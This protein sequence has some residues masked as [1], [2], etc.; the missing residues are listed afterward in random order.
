MRSEFR[1]PLAATVGAMVMAASVAAGTTMARPTLGE[2]VAPDESELRSSG[3]TDGMATAVGTVWVTDVSTD[4]VTVFDAATGSTLT[5]IPVGKK[6]IGLTSPPGSSKVYVSNEGDGTVSV[7]S[8]T[9]LSVV[10]TIEMVV[11]SKPHH[12]ANSPDGR[13][14]YV[15][16]YGTASIAVI[17]TTSDTA[18]IVRSGR[19]GAKTHAIG[20]SPDGSALYVTNTKTND[21]QRLDAE[22]RVTGDPIAVGKGPS[23]VLISPDG[24]TAYV[25]IKDENEVEIVDLST[26]R[27]VGT[28]AVG[29]E[30]DTLTFASGNR[31]VAA[32][33]G[34][35]PS[36]LV[37]VIEPGSSPSASRVAV[38]GT[39]TGHQAISPDG[40]VAYVALTGPTPGVAVVD[41][42]SRTVLATWPT[43]T[44]GSPHGVYLDAVPGTAAVS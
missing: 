5:R 21:I 26:R 32:L 31:V 9:T 29:T 34:K 33:R 15:A 23:E 19:A 3:P 42:D 25:S 16:L 18:Q 12:V 38:G 10:G 43:S 17:D 7:I 44:G 28:V 39:S 13:R 40:R 27:V 8:K 22:G 37:T 4:E 2:V 11:G 36:G 30:P 20:V 14:V 24:R 1:R 6:P 35:G 41:L